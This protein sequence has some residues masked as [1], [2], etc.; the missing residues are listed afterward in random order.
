MHPVT[1]SALLSYDSFGLVQAHLSAMRLDGLR[2]TTLNARLVIL[3]G[4]LRHAKR[5]IIDVSRDDIIN[6]IGRPS[7]KSGTRGV[8]LV[9]L[10][11]FFTWCIGEEH[12]TDDPTDRIK[13]PRQ[14]RGQPH[15]IS[16]TDLSAALLTARPTVRCWLLLGAFA[17]LRCFEMAALTGEEVFLD[18]ETPRMAIHGKGGY[19]GSVPLHPVLVDELRRWPRRGYLFPHNTRPG[20]HI[21]AASISSAINR[22]LRA[23]GIHATAHATRHLFATS[24]YR[25]SGHDL[26]MT[27]EL[28]R[29]AS[30]STTAIYTQV[31][32]GKSAT[33]VGE[34]RYGSLDEGAA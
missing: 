19:T 24:T 13:A 22:H 32:P 12:L 21:L 17:G 6:F 3:A 34:L 11:S 7:L 27:Q 4:L 10:R 5:D 29:H 2:D 15:P 20:H 28:L 33:V 23:L 25:L 1:R 30:P 26:R 14:K 9:H 16:P 18:V 31:E 8:Y